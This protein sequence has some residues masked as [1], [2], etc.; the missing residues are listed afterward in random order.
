MLKYKKSDKVYPSNFGQ[1]WTDSEEVLLL[2]ELDKNIDMQTIAQCHGRTI[3]GI[4]ARRKLIACK[5]YSKNVSMEVIVSKTKLNE[6]QIVE[7]MDKQKNSLKKC[8]S[9]ESKIQEL[10]IRMKELIEMKSEVDNLGE[11]L[12]FVSMV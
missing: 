12:V 11:T 2:E 8:K 6:E 9:L 10:K 5:L 1:K 4:N 3:G 7:T